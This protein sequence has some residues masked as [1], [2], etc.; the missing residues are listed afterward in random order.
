MYL[1]HESQLFSTGPTV[2]ICTLESK[3]LIS[4]WQSFGKVSTTFDFGNNPGIAGLSTSVAGKIL[5]LSIVPEGYLYLSSDPTEEAVSAC[6][7][8]GKY[9]WITRK[10]G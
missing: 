1:T 4:K 7:E 3:S 2:V 9:C 10:T 5:I 8:I 6:E